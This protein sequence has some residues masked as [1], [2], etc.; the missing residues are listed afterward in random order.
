M[1]QTIRNTVKWLLCGGAF[2]GVVV[3]AGCGGHT[4]V[5]KDPPRPIID[6][7]R[8]APATDEKLFDNQEPA[9]T[10]APVINIFGEM[11]GEKSAPVKQLG[12]AGFQQHTFLDEGY[13]ANVSISPEGKWLVFGSTR[14]SEH[15]DIYLQHVDGQSVTQLTADEADDAYPTFSPDGKQIAF[16]STR[17]GTWDIFVMDVDGK[18]VTQVTAGPSQDLHPSFA[19]DGKRIVYSSMGGRSAQWEIWTVNLLSGEKKMIG[20]GL[21]PSWSP[22]KSVDRIAFQRARQR[23]SRWF[24]LWTLDLIDGE[25]RRVTEVAVSSNAAIVSPAWSA[26][27]KKI[28]FGTIVDPQRTSG[29]K[30]EGQQDVW[31]INAD[32]T[33][34]HR[35]TDGNGTNLS[36]FWARDGRV[37]FVSNRGGSE[38]IWSAQADAKIDGTAVTDTKDVS[39]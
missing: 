12:E 27:G 38:C 17:N 30:N 11:N 20:F 26:D 28:A 2:V 34:K 7:Y 5:T 24:S 25:A 9:E 10:Q 3:S 8:T 36:P 18:N 32:G 15:P 35:L 13:D 1:S 4:A 6:P 29:G 21:F 16:S 37:F 23:G 33:N 14:H 39:H 22:D 19:P 31:T